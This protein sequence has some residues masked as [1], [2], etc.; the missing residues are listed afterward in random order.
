MDGQ[1]RLQKDIIALRNENLPGGDPL[2]K[3]VMEKGKA[4]EPY[5]PLEEIRERF[6]EEFN[7]LDKQ[8]KA[9][10][11]PIVYPVELSPRLKNL[12][13]EIEQQVAQAQ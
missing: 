3:K 10:R 8:T 5:P 13:E 2:L 11:N 12:R 4:K 6:L 7:R 1:G 9:I